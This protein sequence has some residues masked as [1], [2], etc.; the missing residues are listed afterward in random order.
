LAAN[1]RAVVLV[2]DDQADI[3]QALD[4]LLTEAG[5]DVEQAANGVEALNSARRRRPRVILLDQ[6]MPELDGR[7]FVDAI[8]ADASL[9]TIPVIIT[10][11]IPMLPPESLPPVFG[12]FFLKPFDIEAL[13]AAVRRWSAKVSLAA[14]LGIGLVLARSKPSNELEANQR[15]SR[16]SAHSLGDRE[17]RLRGSPELLESGGRDEVVAALRARHV[18]E[19]RVRRCD[20]S[21]RSAERASIHLTL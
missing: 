11:A 12:G 15:L 20:G 14:L 3:R 17:T 5:F 10:S 1:E 9:S 21:G 18:D 4:Y 19:N 2:V 7:G 13:I 16:C 8:K 6:A